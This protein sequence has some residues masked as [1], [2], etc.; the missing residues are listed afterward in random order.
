MIEAILFIIFV[1]V[2]LYALLIEPRWFRLRRIKVCTKKKIPRDFTILHLSDTHFIDNN[3]SKRRFLMSLNSLQP[4]FICVT[5][6]IID[7]NDGIEPA[8]EILS[9]MQARIGK[10]AV[11]GNH[12]YWDYHIGDN[13]RYHLFG[14]KRPLHQND[15]ERFCRRLTASGVTVLRD[16]KKNVSFDGMTIRISGTEDPVTQQMN[17]HRTF[18]DL[19]EEV[20]HLLLTHVLDVLV[21]IPKVPVD[22]VLAG[23]THGGQVRL[24]FI[25]GFMCGFQMPRRYLEGFHEM[26]GY[27]MCVSRGMGAT[28]T[29]IPRFFCRP[30]AILIEVTSL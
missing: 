11:L 16:E 30:E 19:N 14:E 22:L 24:P 5:G 23:H 25:G 20:F 2:F 7:N 9:Q 3:E 13:L 26:N 15:I 18:A 6:D 29:L 27:V 12:D 21:Q 10:F 28:R 8:V 17:F 4:D 1:G